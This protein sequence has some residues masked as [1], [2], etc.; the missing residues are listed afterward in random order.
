MIDNKDIVEMLNLSGE[1]SLCVRSRDA[2]ERIGAN[3]LIIEA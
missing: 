3:I 2:T 1:W